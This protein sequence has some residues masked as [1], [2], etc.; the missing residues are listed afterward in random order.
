MPG[1][2]SRIK[3]MP[4]LYQSVVQAL[5]EAIISGSY[6]P[7][8]A[9]PSEM[10]LAAQLGVSRPVVREALRSLQSLGFVEIRRGIKGGAFV[11]DPGRLRLGENLS[12]LI[13]L[14]RVT[15]AHLYQVRAHLEPE[16]C[17]LAALMASDGDL[18]A[19][20]ALQ[21]EY[22]ATAAIDRRVVLNARFH[23]L[24]AQACHNPLYALLIDSIMDFTVEFVRAIKPAER[25]LHQD[26]EHLEILSALQARDPGRAFALMQRHTAN[27]AQE[28]NALENTYLQVMAKAAGKA[29]TR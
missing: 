5:R 10:D 3:Q 14:R 16:V 11:G 17:R 1:K 25:M 27:I 28:M 24:V 19:I 18:T 4:S 13:R 15:V 7:G 6:Q 26:H 21:A 20:A 12:D 2:L 29:R 22:E 9:L 8:D 23:R